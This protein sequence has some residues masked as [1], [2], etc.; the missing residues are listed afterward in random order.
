MRPRRDP[1]WSPAPAGSEWVEALEGR[2]LLE[3][4]PFPTL[5][6]L[7]NPNN[8]VVRLDTNY[9]DIDIELFDTGANAAPI[10]TA[11][12]L[13]YVR[14]G[15]YDESFFHRLAF[16]GDPPDRNLPFVVQGG[17]YRHIDGTGVST[18][19]TQPPIQ[20]E[21]S[22]QRSNLERT[23]AMA[24]LGGNP[25]SATS[26]FFFN[27]RDNS[28]NL[29]NQ[30]GGFTVFARVANDRSWNVVLTIVGLETRNLNAL[31]D[32]DAFSDV[33]VAA[34]TPANPSSVSNA[35]L[36]VL[37]D[38]EVIKARDVQQFYTTRTYYPE[39]FAGATINEFLPMQNTRDETVYYQVI[40][41]AEVP[42]GTA[43]NGYTWFRDRVISTGSLAPN[44]R[45]GITI[46]A[47][48]PGGAPGA[49]DLVPQGVPYAIE[50]Q[51]TQAISANISHYDFGTS[52]GEAF[53]R[54]TATTWALPDAYKQTGANGVSDFLVWMNPNIEPATVTITFVFQ[55]QAPQTASTVTTMLRRG[56]LNLNQMA[57]V[58]DNTAFSI[59][60]SSDRPIVAALT[61]FDSRTAG[62]PLGSAALG[63][64]GS[65]SRFG[66]LP[67]GNVGPG[68]Q[69]TP[70][71]EQIAV[72]NPSTTASVVVNLTLTFTEPGD[73]NRQPLRL[74][75]AAIVQPQR[76]ATI[77]LSNFPQLADGRR[78]SVTYDTLPAGALIYAGW[79]H[80]QSFA[81]IA[82]ADDIAAPLGERAATIWNF[83]EGFMDPA[84]AG[85]DV[86][87]TVSVYNP[88]YAQ[89]FG[90]TTTPANVTVRLRYGDSFI[91]TLPSVQV[92]G[93]GRVD[94]DLHAIQAVL[95]QGTQNQRYFYSI[96]VTSDIAVVAQMRHFDLTLGGASP[97]GGF[98]TLGEAFGTITR[99]D[100]LAGP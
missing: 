24:K 99:L 45:G 92:A 26:Q 13:G 95:N 72:M 69:G 60:L 76:R 48:G 5:A 36:V 47:F 53:T 41:R 27:L 86:F 80:R 50:I 14:R 55:N 85:V 52:T 1:H 61:H 23:I 42:Q 44:S 38:A 70:N 17:G 46:S 87:E 30:N 28:A 57:Q 96:E 8:T 40:A 100:A 16:L 34:G 68:A 58:P 79:H 4:S 81:G 31:L 3:G 20:N 63:S 9:G 94:F 93:G 11:N 33:P 71:T 75:A 21:F 89:I 43:A 67:F 62:D 7:T 97:S 32:P 51:S 18:I 84:R 10:T 22:P 83:A 98:S 19:P 78:Y 6:E 66:V 74:A 56:G 29:D 90:A 54:T 2:A 91:L 88:H 77:N 64:S 59:L 82:N 37:R 73:P 39:G 65:G 15:E 25:N 35:M 12:F 49:N